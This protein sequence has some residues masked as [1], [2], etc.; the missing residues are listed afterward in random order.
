MNDQPRRTALL[1]MG[2]GLLLAGCVITAEPMFVRVPP[3]LPPPRAEI[4]VVQPGPAYVW[5]TGHWVWRGGP[6]YVW[7]P[8]HWEMPPRPNVVYAPGHW[9][10]RPNGHAWVE[11][12]W[13]E[14]EKEKEREHEGRGREKERGRER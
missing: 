4:V 1:G 13:R 10:A 11:G 9:E 3:P 7:T 12:Q 5:I 2:A 6:S 14:R 8:G